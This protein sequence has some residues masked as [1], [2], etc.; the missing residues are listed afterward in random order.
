MK[1]KSNYSNSLLFLNI[2]ISII[3]LF[4]IFNESKK[5]N[6]LNKKLI[7]IEKKL[8]ETLVPST[9]IKNKKN[10]RKRNDWKN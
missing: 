8:D 1:R 10:K 6:Q 3:I 2:L 7:K 9:R 4:F 5:N